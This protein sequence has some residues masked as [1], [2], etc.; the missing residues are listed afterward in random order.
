MPVI[1]QEKVNILASHTLTESS[2]HTVTSSNS[3]ISEILDFSSVM[4]ACQ[5][6]SEQ[7]L[8]EQLIGKL[9]QVAIEN[10]VATKGILILLNNQTLLLAAKALI[11]EKE[12]TVSCTNTEDLSS[13]IPV[14]VIN[15]IQQ[16]RKPL[17]VNNPSLNNHWMTDAY[18]QQNSPQCLLGLPLLHQNKLLGIL[19]L[20]NQL[21]ADI[22]T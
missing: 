10:A 19:Y 20:E 16:I 17:V 13:E 3:S 6:L 5:A 12:V 11:H 1:R 22:F 14:T 18:I 7:I 8:L 4:K 15:Y 9:M 21:T 2:R